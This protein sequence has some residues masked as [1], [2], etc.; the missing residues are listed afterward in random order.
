MRI[1][2]TVLLVACY[3]APP[4]AAII[5]NRLSPSLGSGLGVGYA[6]LFGLAL[7]AVATLLV[8]LAGWRWPSIRPHYWVVAAAFGLCVILIPLG[9]SGALSVVR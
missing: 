5:N 3:L 9:D 4:V 6:I 1:L 7:G 8:A 2:S